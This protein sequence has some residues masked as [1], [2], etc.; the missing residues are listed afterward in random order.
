[1][2]LFWLKGY[3]LP[4]V[5]RVSQSTTP[6]ISPWSA[7]EFHFITKSI[8][9]LK[10]FG[11]IS[12]CTP[13][14]GQFLFPIFLVPKPDGSKRFILNLKHLNKF[15]EPEH[16]KLEYRATVLNLMRPNCFMATIDLQDAYFMIPVADS[17]K[18]Y[19]R[20]EFNGTLYEFN[21]LPF[22]LSTTPYVFTN[23]MKQVVASI[24]ARVLFPWFVSMIFGLWEIPMRIVYKMF[25]KLL[26]F[27]PS[28]DSLLMNGKV[29]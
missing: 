1:M 10:S 9:K 2:V 27:L 24:R 20:F 22:G 21:C 28:W 18:K 14:E 26:A 8:H 11:A 3:E 19:L 12:S 16:F 23:I 17:Y 15:L 6:A 29:L 7:N 5:R 13:S 25:K 4:F